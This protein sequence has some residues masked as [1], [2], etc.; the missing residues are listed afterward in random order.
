[1]IGDKFKSEIAEVTARAFRELAGETGAGPAMADEDLN[2]F[3]AD[4]IF[5]TL[6]VPKK[7]EMGNYALPLFN[8]AGLLGQ[9]P[10]ELN[11][12]LAGIQNGIVQSE[13]RLSHL[14]FS[15]VGGF[16]NAR[17]STEALAAETLQAVLTQERKYGSSDE[18]Q[19]RNIVIDFSSPNIA[20]PFGI[21]H[22]RTTAIGNSLYRIFEKLGY[23]SIGI[24]HLGDWGT[25]FGKMIVAFR[26]WGSEEEVKDDPVVKLFNLYVK[27]HEEEEK[28]SSLSDQ[29]REAFKNLEHGEPEETRLWN[30]FK[31]Y[32]L[33]AFKKTY[34]L[35]GVQFDYYT[36]ESFYND[37]M[38]A[39]IDDLK[40][41][42]LA[43]ISEG[44]L[45][46][47]LDK[48]GLPPCMLRKADGATLYA[49]R[50]ITGI[51]YRW[52]Q[53]QFNK[54]LYVVG[55]AQRDHFQQVFKVVELYEEARQIPVDKRF[56]QGLEH[57]EFGW[58]KF[59]DEMMSTRKGNIIFLDDVLNKA[60][61]LARK[62]ILEKNP[63]LK[64]IDRTARQIGI[65]AVL[66]ADM[67]TRR[68]KD[69]NFEWDEVLNFEGE[70]GPYLQY[71]HARLS[72]LLRNYG[73]GV[74]AEVDHSLL[75]MPEE[76][77][78]LDL[79]YKFPGIVSEAAITYE[80]YII[81][82]YL[83]ELAAAFNK[84]YQRK[85]KSGRIDKIISDN[86]E[87]TRA[88]MALVGAVKIV[89][90]E[91]LHLLGIESPDEM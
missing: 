85:D 2:K 24:N 32:S 61:D 26:K 1:M 9:N 81:S 84:V 67:S 45:V 87:L 40:E 16:N 70:T 89:V 43:E 72:S 83:L 63:D 71:T 76:Y 59:K 49:T 60:I 25:Q 28:D 64:E 4:Q 18:G 30:M 79:L 36:G 56:S 74:S 78:V 19:G 48:Y 66:F 22:L 14:S 86:A 77:R 35:L 10:A 27:F 46:V 42:G 50:D 47:N 53:F 11:R 52:K 90:K 65:G 15:A 57:V 54:V 69:V 8:L 62:K 17:I 7:P 82:S 68:Q 21:G 33:Q 41:A 38:P 31:E 88:R 5:G 55:S 58:I 12:K 20:K 80:P 34:E 3:T 39:V 73:R 13:A 44:A 29:A 75:D 37:Q 23:N 6:E 51:F 91:G